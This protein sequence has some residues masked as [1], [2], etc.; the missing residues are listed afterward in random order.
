M[1]MIVKNEANYNYTPECGK[2]QSDGSAGLIILFNIYH[3]K[4]MLQTINIP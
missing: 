4:F 3:F 1:G 2:M